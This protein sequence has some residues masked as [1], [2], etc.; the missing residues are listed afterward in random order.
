[1]IQLIAKNILFVRI[2]YITISLFFLYSCKQED[3]NNNKTL[4]VSSN[5]EIRT[6]DPVMASDL[7][8]CK[9]IVNFYDT[10]LQY[11]FVKR[12]YELKPSALKIMPEISNDLLTYTFTIRNDLFF[13]NNKCFQNNIQRKISSK[14]VIFSILRLADARLNSPGYWLIRGK[15]KGVD[16]FREKTAKLKSDDFSVYDEDWEGFEIIDENKFIIKMVTPEPRLLYALAMPYSSIVSRQSVEYYKDTFSENP[17]GSGPFILAEW[18][19]HYNIILIKNRNYRTEYFPDAISEHSK[20][21]KLPYLDKIVSYS[22]KQPLS[23]WLMFLQGELDI[24]SLDK[25]NFDAVVTSN[26]ELVDCLK[27]RKIKMIESSDFEINYIGFSFSNELI[28][29]N[30]NLRKAISYA[31]NID[32][33]IKHFNYRISMANG[34]IPPSVAGYDDKFINEYNKF[35]IK[36]AR[37]FLE[38]AGYPNGINPETN[39]NLELTFDLPGS[40]SAHRQIAELMVKDMALIGIKIK[41]F[42]NSKTRFFQ[43]LRKGQVQLFRLS[44]IGDYPDAENFLQLFYGPYSKACNRVCYDNPLF[45]KLFEEIMTMKDSPERTEKYKFMSQFLVKDVPWIFESYPK[46]YILTY[47]WLENYKSHN[48]AFSQWKY[49]NINKIKKNKIKKLFKPM[50]IRAN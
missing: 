4:F 12:P 22:V 7:A 24:C 49:W 15:I 34:P 43:K 3:V 35:D 1:M 45:N 42:L 13:Q 11:D 46:S 17:V 30:L 19:K 27:E 26:N 25:D 36:K 5:G 38:K 50:T 37:S 28:A 44:W 2:L 31:Y 18:N 33:R 40:S 48:F 32:T 21:E 23:N 47:D 29:K 9:M 16:K 10:L 14:D 20:K 39:R 41:P 6:L 8:S